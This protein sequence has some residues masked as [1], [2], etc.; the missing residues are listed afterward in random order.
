MKKLSILLLGIVISFFVLPRESQA[1]S[2]ADFTP[3]L[4]K[5][6]ARMKTTQEKVEWLQ[7]FSDSLAT[8]K[9]TK[10]KDA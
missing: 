2:V 8:P 5:K 9:Y 6:V 3:V 4:D 10:S 1:L 7:S